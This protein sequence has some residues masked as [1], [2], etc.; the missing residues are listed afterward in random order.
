M[1]NYDVLF[2]QQLQKC[3]DL[4]GFNYL[5]KWGKECLANSLWTTEDGTQARTCIRLVAQMDDD[6]LFTWANTFIAKA[7][8]EDISR[9][10]LSSDGCISRG[11]SIKSG[12]LSRT[13]VCCHAAKFAKGSKRTELRRWFTKTFGSEITA[14]IIGGK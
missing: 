2:A 7:V 5:M 13:N 10:P 11:W 8:W 3:S 12:Q 4:L 14:A 9:I 1:P 6:L